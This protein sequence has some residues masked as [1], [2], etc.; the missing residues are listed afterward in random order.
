MVAQMVENYYYLGDVEKARDLVARF[1]DQLTETARFYLEWGSLG[2]REFETASRMLLYVSD[3]CKQYGDTDL[4]EAIVANLEALLHAA[5]G[6]SYRP[7]SRSS[8]SLEVE[9]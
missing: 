8:D 9:G 6:G 4:S 7:E 3:V 2:S 1:G 5:S